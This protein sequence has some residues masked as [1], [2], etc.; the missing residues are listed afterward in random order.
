MFQGAHS[1]LTEMVMQDHPINQRALTNA[2]CRHSHSPSVEPTIGAGIPVVALLLL[3][4][5]FCN[6]SFD[7]VSTLAGQLYNYALKRLAN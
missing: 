5:H 4:V 7:C 1:G 2:L 6:P 3:P